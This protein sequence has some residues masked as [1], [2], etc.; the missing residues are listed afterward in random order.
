MPQPGPG[1]QQPPGGVLRPAAGPQARDGFGGPRR[2][3]VPG[4]LPGP[5]PASLAAAGLPAG[6]DELGEDFASLVA[7]LAGR[8]YGWPGA[9]ARRRLLAG[10]GPCPGGER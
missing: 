1:E 10:S 2:A 8:R 4:E 7:A 5:E 3:R 9:D 6:R